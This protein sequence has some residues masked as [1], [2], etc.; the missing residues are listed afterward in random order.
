M[1]WMRRLGLASVALLLIV[2]S[3]VGI[4]EVLW[5]GAH[6]AAVAS[7][8]SSAIL[9]PSAI[10]AARSPGSRGAG[11][12][13]QTK[14]GRITPAT[15]VPQNAP[16]ERVLPGIRERIGEPDFAPPAPPPPLNQ[17]PPGLSGPTTPAG[18]GEAP[19]PSGSFPP[20]TFS[21]IPPLT[22]PGPPGQQTPPG[23]GPPFNP[24]TSPVPEPSAWLLMNLA[25]FGVG[26]ALRRARSRNRAAQRAAAGSH[27]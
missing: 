15:Y 27:A 10:F 26:A 19:P 12:L 7:A 23:G 21:S 3:A 1:K 8:V 20:T 24:P 5:R 22:G 18:G 2:G 13:Q 17:T 4:D 9:D 25:L 6:A 14:P 16:E 11:P